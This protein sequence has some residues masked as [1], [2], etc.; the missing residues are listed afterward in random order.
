M[1]HLPSSNSRRCHRPL[2]PEL[3]RGHGPGTPGA[4]RFRL[5]RGLPLPDRRTAGTRKL[6]GSTDSSRCGSLVAPSPLTLSSGWEARPAQGC[7]SRK[8]SRR[9]LVGLNGEH[10]HAAPEGEVVADGR[11]GG[12]GLGVLP[13]GGLVPSLANHRG[14][15]ARS[16]LPRAGRAPAARLE[17]APVDILGR[18]VV[19]ALDHDR[20]VALREHRTVPDCAHA[21]AVTRAGDRTAQSPDHAHLD[22]SFG[23][24]V[25]RR[26]DGALG[27]WDSAT[28]N[29]PRIARPQIAATTPT[30]TT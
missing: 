26:S 7:S 13:G 16:A 2:H 29:P 14:V 21:L 30:T 25:S 27:A 8:P 3:D 17:V 18:E 1:R 20:A 15:V 28:L 12:Q 4:T 19:V 11:G 22:A 23:S 6:F 10:A 24:L 5:E 9:A